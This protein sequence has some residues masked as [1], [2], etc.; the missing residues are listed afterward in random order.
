MSAVYR[1]QELTREEMAAADPF[2][3]HGVFLEAPGDGSQ[4]M[5]ARLAACLGATVPAV[6]WDDIGIW[7]DPGSSGMS[8]VSIRDRWVGGKA[9]EHG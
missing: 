4:A 2:G 8:A 5:L 1:M 7:V 3:G 6:A 9:S